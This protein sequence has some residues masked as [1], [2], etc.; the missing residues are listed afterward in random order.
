MNLKLAEYISKWLAPKEYR[1]ELKNRLENLCT[2]SGTPMSPGLHQWV[3]DKFGLEMT[4]VIEDYSTFTSPKLSPEL[5]SVVDRIVPSKYQGENVNL[6]FKQLFDVGCVIPK[7]LY[8]GTNT[9][10]SLGVGC[11]NFWEID[12]IP[13]ASTSFE[14]EIG[15][16]LQGYD[17][18]SGGFTASYSLSS[19]K[20]WIVQNTLPTNWQVFYG[21]DLNYYP[22]TFNLLSCDLT[23][24][25][26]KTSFIGVGLFLD[27]I[28]FKFG[29]GTE[30]ATLSGFSTSDPQFVQI[31]QG[32]FGGNAI[33]TVFDDGIK[34]FIQIDGAYEQISPIALNIVGLGLVNFIE[35]TC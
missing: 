34:T 17:S 8:Y 20:V 16:A 13:I 31:L 25:C 6:L 32:L 5:L 24:K 29:S 10:P 33:I 15:T 23:Q 9:A 14:W 2:L 21:C 30:F 18:E 26:Y 7:C 22:V 19:T 1:L 27:Y 4:R 12:N 28:Q 35:S 3:T 11:G